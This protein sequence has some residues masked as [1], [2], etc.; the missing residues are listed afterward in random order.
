MHQHGPRPRE[1][2]HVALALPAIVAAEFLGTTL[3]FSTNAVSPDISRAL[4]RGGDLLDLSSPVQIGFVA[5]TLLLAFTGL[6]DRVR[7]SQIF[8]WSAL[9]GAAANALVCLTPPILWQL[10]LWRAVTGF[11][12]AGIYPIGMKL[13][14]GW[15]PSAAK[16]T[17]GWLVGM[18]TLGTAFPHLV[19]YANVGLDWRDVVLTSSMLAAIAGMVVAFVGDG[20]VRPVNGGREKHVVAVMRDFQ[21]RPLRHAA[22]AYLG[23][24]WEL[25]AFWA[26]VPLLLVHASGAQQ[27]SSELARDAF[28]II[29][30]GSAGCI[31]GGYVSKKFG[32]ERVACWSMAISALACLCFPLLADRAAL[33]A[34]LLVWGVF[35]IAD[36]PQLSTLASE[37]AAP[38]RIAS[39]LALLNGTGFLLT[40][41]SIHLSIWA[42]PTM[43]AKVAWLLCPGPFL[44][45]MMMRAQRRACTHSVTS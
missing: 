45:A 12:L 20:P 28:G 8:L 23:H 24:M 11:A 22:L 4:D 7:A 16:S 1:A 19:R 27:P 13:A 33:F 31:L 35:V 18:L 25:Y 32:S 17:L 36:S 40:A 39:T 44:G 2:L 21:S 34:L 42:W 15:K 5:G 37:A 26:M 30:A 41:L 9:L 3:W 14:I 38:K 43:G 10:M 6:G 29:A